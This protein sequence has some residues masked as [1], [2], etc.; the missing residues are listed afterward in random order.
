MS[1][2]QLGSCVQHIRSHDYVKTARSE[3]LLYRRML[4]IEQAIG[5]EGRSRKFDAC[6]G[7]E[8]RMTHP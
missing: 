5:D 7:Q 2:A 1:A 3:T 6:L 8:R 4:N